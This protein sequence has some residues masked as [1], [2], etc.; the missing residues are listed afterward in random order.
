MM[1]DSEEFSP[2]DRSP[3]DRKEFERRAAAVGMTLPEYLAEI[4]KKELDQDDNG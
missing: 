4:I 2:F 1:A 3:L